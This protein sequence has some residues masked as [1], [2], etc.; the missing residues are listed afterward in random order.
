MTR[1]T[2]SPA[3]RCTSHG[4]AAGRYR[5]GLCRHHW[6]EAEHAPPA[7]P[8]CGQAAGQPTQAC[9]VCQ[10]RLC[11]ACYGPWRGLSCLSCQ[12]PA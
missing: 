3:E 5:S 2:Y 1:A 12:V 11:P 8:C 4:C 10:R 6:N 7:P 9:A